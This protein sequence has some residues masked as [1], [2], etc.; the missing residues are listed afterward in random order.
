MVFIEGRR[1][2]LQRDEKIQTLLAA[3]I[4]KQPHLASNRSCEK[5]AT[6]RTMLVKENQDF[7]TIDQP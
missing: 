7:D 6:A 3:F 1:H 2:N 4:G 5:I